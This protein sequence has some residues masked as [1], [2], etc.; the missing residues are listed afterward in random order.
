MN[1]EIGIIG[2]SGFYSLLEDVEK[3][4][5]KTIYG[6]TSDAISIGRLAGKKVAFLPRHGNNHTIPPHKVPYRANIEALSKLGVSRIIAT[7]AVGSLKPEYRPGDIVLFDQFVNMAG[8]RD[9]T[10]FDRDLVVH[11]SSAEPYCS[12]LRSIAADAAGKLR[13]KNHRSGTVLVIN[14][15]RF[16]SKAESKIFSSYGCDVINMTQ[17]PECM[18]AREKQICYLGI[19]L[20]TDYDAGL[21]GRSDIKAVS[22]ADV[23]R[24]FAENI[25]KAKSL[26]AG[27]VKSIP[28]ARS[29]SC[30]SALD[31]A[32]QTKR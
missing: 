10:F 8:G 14:G 31:G 32:V 18:L 3:V 9:D 27:T 12:Q 13:I 6:K 15:P 26:I 25:D 19:G 21:E 22:A 28:S 30:H 20:I 5:V 11:V 4:N 1:A 24:I 29:C 2:G 16:S 7:N 17:Y 23:M